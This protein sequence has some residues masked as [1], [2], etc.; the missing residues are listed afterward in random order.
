MF[1]AAVHQPESSVRATKR[2]QDRNSEDPT[3]GS[4]PYPPA[5]RARHPPPPSVPTPA[6]TFSAGHASAAPV[7]ARD[8]AGVSLPL[9]RS[10]SRRH[11]PP[12]R[13]RKSGLSPAVLGRR[14]QPRDTMRF[15]IHAR[16][17]LSMA[18]VCALGALSFTLPVACSLVQLQTTRAFHPLQP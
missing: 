2:G 11:P 3:L 9:P 14:Q 12:A 7:G 4:A 15:C 10:S 5:G 13:A 8:H 18:L 16:D 6:T 17:P 1:S